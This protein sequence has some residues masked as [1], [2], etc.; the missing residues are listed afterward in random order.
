MRLS[1][2]ILAIALGQF[3]LAS[4]SHI[5]RQAY[6]PAPTES[7][8]APVAPS[9]VAIQT[10]IVSS[11]VVDLYTGAYFLTGRHPESSLG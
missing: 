6:G 9:T 4:P 5:R 10:G 3:A 1:A 7:G 2:I 8:P 11:V